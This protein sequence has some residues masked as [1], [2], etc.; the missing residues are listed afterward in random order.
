MSNSSSES[1]V[2][3]L[4]GLFE[5]ITANP[6]ALSVLSSLLG[7][8][9]NVPTPSTTVD[10]HENQTAGVQ[11]MKE[12]PSSATHEKRQ[13]PTDK[14]VR[15]LCAMRPFFEGERAQTLEKLIRIYEI[16]HLLRNISN[17]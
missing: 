11:A 12:L 10:E 6:G 3:D 7:N 15:F 14:R 1:A 9:K 13:E 16:L 4:S 5:K 8:A 2:P 17:R